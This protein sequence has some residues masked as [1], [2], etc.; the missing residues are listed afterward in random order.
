MFKTKLT[1]AVLLANSLFA[2]TVVL[3]NITVTA[4]KKEENIQKVPISISAYDE[5]SIEDKSIQKLE[6]IAKFTPNLMLYNTGQEGLIVPS[7]RGISGNVLS[8][9]TPVG[10]YVDGIPTTS[11]FGFSDSLGDIERIEVLRGPQGT[12]YGK[13]SEAG[14]INIISKQPDNE[15]RAKFIYHCK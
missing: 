8:Y 3:E 10:L 2:Q 9:S 11:A 14:V 15:T 7:I 1:V 4:Q 6:D 12:L 13:N 5:I